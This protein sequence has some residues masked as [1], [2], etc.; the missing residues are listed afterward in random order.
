MSAAIFALLA[1][2]LTT[3]YG[4]KYEQESGLVKEGAAWWMIWATLVC[5]IASACCFL[6]GCSKK[7]NSFAIGCGIYCF[8]LTEII[9]LICGILVSVS[10]SRNENLSSAGKG[11]GISA[12]VF[13]ICT[14][15]LVL[16]TIVIMLVCVVCDEC[17]GGS[18]DGDGVTSR[19]YQPRH[20]KTAKSGD[21]LTEDQKRQLQ[22]YLNSLAPEQRN[23]IIQYMLAKSQ[24]ENPTA[25]EG[26]TEEQVQ[27]IIVMAIATN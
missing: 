16:L 5:T 3:T 25:P 19:S 8:I 26:M 17:G 6:A 2:V 18:S 13:I 9:M 7:T 10:V 11:V 14:M 12:A 4:N 15:F 24:G 20:E 22:A 27:I 23:A 1:A 21:S